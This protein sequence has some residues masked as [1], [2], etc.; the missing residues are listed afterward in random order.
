MVELEIFPLRMIDGKTVFI[1]EVHYTLDAVHGGPW[2]CLT[3]QQRD[4]DLYYLTKRVLQKDSYVQD[5]TQ[6]IFYNIDT[7]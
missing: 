1:T 2:M 3:L 7:L 4:N 6:D 5:G